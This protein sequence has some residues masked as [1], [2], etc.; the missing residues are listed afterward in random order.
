MWGLFLIVI[1]MGGIY[2]GIFTPTEAAA[3]SAVY[4]FVI[5][6]FVYKD[7]TI[8]DVPRVLLDSANMSAMLL[9][10]ITNAVL[11]SFL[12]TH[13]N[14]PQAMADWMIGTGVGVIGFLLIAN[15]LL[16]VAGNFMEPSSIVLILAPI[17]FPIAVK[18][19]IDPVHFGILMVV[20]MEVGMCHPPVGLN[21]YVSSGITKMGI[22]ELTV[23]VWPWL[24]TML[25]FLV[26][27]TY[28][29]PLSLILPRAL[30]MV[31]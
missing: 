24:L 30:G 17:L 5:S 12:M 26:I 28:W 19:G 16:L 9:Y 21:L 10:I 27:V 20:N 22:T 18:L 7:L 25:V 14:I 23:A 3:M 6:V 1:V 29:P 11:F 2:S 31:S 4:A 8:K 13:E 15:I